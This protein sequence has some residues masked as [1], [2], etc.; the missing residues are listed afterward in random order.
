MTHKNTNTRSNS[1]EGLNAGQAADRI[2]S[3]LWLNI[4]VKVNDEVIN[5]PLGVSLEAIEARLEKMAKADVGTR[6]ARIQNLQ[7]K[8]IAK[9]HTAF[10]EMDG[11]DR[12]VFN[13]L[14]VEGYRVPDAPIDNTVDTSDEE[15]IIENME[16]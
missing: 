9:L 5:L 7:R 16:F 8:L 11:G 3:K 1:L 10:D 4:S 12:R 6:T 13:N 14:V 2:E 15:E